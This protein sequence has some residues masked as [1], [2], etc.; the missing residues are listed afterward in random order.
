MGA[1]WP[2]GRCSSCAVVQVTSGT[3]PGAGTGA[4]GAPVLRGSCVPS[5]SE[6][7]LAGFHARAFSSPAPGFSQVLGLFTPC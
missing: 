6:D 4:L 1:N 5:T 3:K 7:P 2:Q